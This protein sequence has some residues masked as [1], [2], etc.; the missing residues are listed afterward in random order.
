MKG[1]SAMSTPVPSARRIAFGVLAVGVIGVAAASASGTSSP[2]ADAA[3][4]NCTASGLATTASGVLG[5]AG[6][7][8]ADHP[9]AN[10]ALTEAASQPP[11]GARSAVESYFMAH[12]GEFLELQGIAQP[13]LSMR[14][15][16][17][18]SLSPRR[19]SAILDTIAG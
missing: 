9:A 15:Q 13:L 18:D 10:D 17:G 16:C 3:P 2:T 7:Y 1:T 5:Q 6:G 8:L 14:D 11:E 19:I 12:P 4:G